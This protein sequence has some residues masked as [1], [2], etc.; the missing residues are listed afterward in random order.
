[1]KEFISVKL[2]LA[3]ATVAM[4]A[5]HYINKTRRVGLMNSSPRTNSFRV[6]IRVTSR[7]NTCS[8]L[9]TRWE[10]NRTA[11][12]RTRTYIRAQFLQALITI[13]TFSAVSWLIWGTPVVARGNSAARCKSFEI[14]SFFTRAY[15]IRY[16]C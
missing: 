4:A 8:A 3:R 5:G 13:N 14:Y 2:P 12:G 15:L 9:L 11:R 10:L 16:N 7:Y 1:M 6:Y